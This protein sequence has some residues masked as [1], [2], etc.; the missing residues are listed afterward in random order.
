MI[1]LE[2]QLQNYSD[3]ISEK[4]QY[5]ATNR[6]V[7]GR[8]SKKSLDELSNLI[9]SFSVLSA[10]SKNK[11]FVAESKVY[12]D[13]LEKFA[14]EFS[15][16]KKLNEYF[17]NPFDSFD[18][19]PV[20]TKKQEKIV[21]KKPEGVQFKRI[22]VWNSDVQDKVMFSGGKMLA[23]KF[24]KAG[25]VIERCPVK[26]IKRT[27]LY[28]DMINRFAIPIDKNRNLYGFPYGN[29]V[30]YRVD[31]QS[32][33][34]GNAEYEF[35]ENCGEPYIRIVATKTIKKGNEIILCSDSLD[36]ENEIKDNQFKYQ[37]GPEPFYAVK[38]FKIV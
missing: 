10:G 19:E 2:K 34:D 1:N 6:Y 13:I 28:Y 21:D 22:N 27:D 30:L 12:F 7:C 8:V 15:Y 31:K 38:N 24:F 3:S 36:F 9:E 14:N 16:A 32:G 18:D 23:C 37:R 35:I 17:E 20:E 25:D 11:E 29:A 5:A 26:L 33:L 4:L